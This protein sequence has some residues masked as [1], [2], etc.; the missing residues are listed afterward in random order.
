[1]L[2]NIVSSADRVPSLDTPESSFIQWFL[3]VN[4]EHFVSQE[5]Q[6]PVSYVHC[7]LPPLAIVDHL[8]IFSGHFYLVC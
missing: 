7:Y 5:L 3:L 8:Q 1:M 2:V 6:S 4:G